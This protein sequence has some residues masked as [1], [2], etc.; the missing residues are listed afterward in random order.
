MARVVKFLRASDFGWF[1]SAWFG[2]RKFAI[3]TGGYILGG[4]IFVVS[5]GVYVILLKSRGFVSEGMK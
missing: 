2:L 5:T 3:K 4:G 1:G